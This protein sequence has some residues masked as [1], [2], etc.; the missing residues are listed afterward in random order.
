[1]HSGLMSRLITALIIF[2]VM[3]PAAQAWEK[4]GE[5]RLK[6]GFFPIYSAELY[7]PDGDYKTEQQPLKLYLE[8]ERRIRAHHFLKHAKKEWSHQGMSEEDIEKSLKA[9][10]GVFPDIQ[11]GE[12]LTLEMKADG[13]AQLYYNTE[14]TYHVTDPDVAKNLID[15][16]LSEDTSR[17]KHRRKLLGDS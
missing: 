13:T 6:V 10:D 11:D 12:S 8:Y 7:T 2:C 1:M 3:S 17:P 14:P 16:W 4:V 15:I 5:A 9:L